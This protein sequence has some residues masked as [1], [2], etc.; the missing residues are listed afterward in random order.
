MD[1]IH[2]KPEMEFTFKT[3]MDVRNMLTKLLRTKPDALKL[4]LSMV[5]RWDSAG[6]ALVVEIIKG[7]RNENRNLQIVGLTPA[8]LSL[9]DFC[10][11]KEIL[12]TV[13]V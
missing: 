1:I 5:T 3:V 10:G 6:I 12:E 11:V 7:C 2:Y 9:A 13:S 8:T 4:D